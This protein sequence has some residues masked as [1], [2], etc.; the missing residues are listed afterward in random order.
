MG[1]VLEKWLRKLDCACDHAAVS[2]D[3]D[4]QMDAQER[5]FAYMAE[6]YNKQDGD[7]HLQ[8]GY[9]CEQCKNKGDIAKAVWTDMGYWT[10][11][12]YECQCKPIRNN[13]NR[14]HKSGLQ[15]VI[16]KYRFD[17]YETTEPWQETVKQNA[18]AYAEAQIGSA[19]QHRWF[20]VGGASGAGKSHI[21]TAICR[22]FLHQGKEVRYMLWRDEAVKLKAMV[23]DTVQY[24]KTMQELKTVEVLYVDDFFKCGQ[25]EGGVQK[26]TAADVNL[27]FEILN[28]RYNNPGFITIISS[29]STLDEIFSI[30]EAVGG[31]IGERAQGYVINL[32]GKEKNYRR[33][34]L[35]FAV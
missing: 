22:E 24:E 34:M 23:N 5:Y 14:M 8:D 1:F 11:V 27:A 33:K 12:H 29:E 18:M 28:H 2:E 7:L 20:F 19:A 32:S 15:A 9:V 17:T 3:S 6:Q 25:V 26:P 10:M 21:C 4:T 30:D 13:I 35:G 31:R 16:G